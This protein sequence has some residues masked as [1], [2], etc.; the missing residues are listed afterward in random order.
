[1]IEDSWAPS[2]IRLRIR[3]DTTAGRVI[4]LGF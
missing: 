1:M 4:L 2:D 3:F